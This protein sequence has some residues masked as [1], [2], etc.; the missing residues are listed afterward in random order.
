MGSLIHEWIKS[1]GSLG[2]WGKR[3]G[4]R[5]APSV[6]RRPAS[7]KLA[8]AWEAMGREKWGFWMLDA[9]RRSSENGWAPIAFSAAWAPQT[10]AS[11]VAKLDFWRHK[12]SFGGW[13]KGWGGS[14]NWDVGSWMLEGRDVSA[15]PACNLSPWGL[16]C[17]SVY[18]H[19]A[20]PKN[21]GNP[22]KFAPANG[23]R[24]DP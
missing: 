13:R 15:S 4:S 7:V 3:R 22:E 20:R 21:R 12:P 9:R 1:G 18:Y 23:S 11:F 17:T 16:V 19:T 6:P 2:G 5:Q 10:G 24:M 8:R 14:R